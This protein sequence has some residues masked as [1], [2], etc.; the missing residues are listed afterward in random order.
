MGS[1]RKPILSLE[2]KRRRPQGMAHLA[3]SA[4]SLRQDL[5]KNTPAGLL[6]AGVPVEAHLHRSNAHLGPQAVSTNLARIRRGQRIASASPSCASTPHS[7][8]LCR[9]L[10]DR[11]R[12]LPGSGRDRRTTPPRWTVPGHRPSLGHHTRRQAAGHDRTGRPFVP[13]A[14]TTGNRGIRPASAPRLRDCNTWPRRC[15]SRAPPPTREDRGPR[16]HRSGTPA[17]AG[18]SRFAWWRWWRSE[19]GPAGAAARQRQPF[20]EVHRQHGPAVVPGGPARRSA[21]LRRRDP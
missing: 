4:H 15:R 13:P 2:G 21:V 11:W 10:A 20:C 17:S 3:I 16:R 9:R 19:P 6:C 1:V 12:V 18:R 5:P 14:M 8:P 7:R